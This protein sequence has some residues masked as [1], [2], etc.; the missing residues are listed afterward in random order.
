LFMKRP[1]S[2]EEAEKR[3]AKTPKTREVAEAGRPNSSETLPKKTP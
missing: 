2:S 1:R 3:I